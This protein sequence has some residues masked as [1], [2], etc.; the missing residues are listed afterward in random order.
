MA[1]LFAANLELGVAKSG[2]NTSNYGAARAESSLLELCRVVTEFDS[3]QIKQTAT[4]L[5]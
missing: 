3:N 4:E 2:K 5:K 1:L